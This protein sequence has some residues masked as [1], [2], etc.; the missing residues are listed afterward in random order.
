MSQSST[1]SS[2]LE[3]RKDLVDNAVE[4]LLDKSISSSPLTKKIEF[5]ESKGLTQDEIQQALLKSQQP[6]QSESHIQPQQQQQ[7]QQQQQVSSPMTSTPSSTTSQQPP[8]R[9]PPVP[10]YYYNAPPIPER[11]W[12]DYFIMA[13]ATAGVSY[14]IYQIVKRYIIPK[15]LPPSKQQIEKDKESIDNEFIRVESLLERFEEEQIKFFEKQNNKSIKIDETLKEIDEIIIKTNEKNLSNEETLKYL[16]LEIENMKNTMMKNLD[17]QKNIISRELNNIESEVTNLKILIKDNKSKNDELV[18]SIKKLNS[19]NNDSSNI[20]N[21][22]FNSTKPSTTS[23]YSNLNI[24]PASSIP[25]VKD[26]L[27]SQKAK[28]LPQQQDNNI[29]NQINNLESGLISPPSNEE[30]E[31]SQ[32][33]SHDQIIPNQTSSVSPEPT[34]AAPATSAE[35]QNNSIKSK[36]GI[37]AWQLAA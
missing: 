10:E 28:S 6:Q 23:N 13:T 15:I 9:P 30:E 29:K 31:E 17:N 34:P 22:T 33:E 4:F 2:S 1:S 3:I 19:N 8:V 12:K 27:L 14:G 24:P 37:P 36:A 26:I 25:S 18:S 16:K 11:D 5:M 7:Q 35:S 21:T 20:T 32:T